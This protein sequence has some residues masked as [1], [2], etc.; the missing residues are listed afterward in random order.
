M[1]LVIDDHLLRAHLQGVLPE[2]LAS[3]RE[4]GEPMWTTRRFQA[5][6]RGAL[7]SHRSVDGIHRRSIARSL[8]AEIV[9]RIEGAA[10]LADASL[11][12]TEM[13]AIAASTGYTVPLWLEALATAKIVDG[14]LALAQVNFSGR[15][16]GPFVAV[17]DATGVRVE[18]VKT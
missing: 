17:A 14:A 4:P 1:R 15:M 12:Q 10:L 18:V 13:D 16:I 7:E 9:R 11:V 3:L 2:A 8:H 6:L 5:R